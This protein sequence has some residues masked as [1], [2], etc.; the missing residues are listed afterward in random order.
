MP[1]AKYVARRGSVEDGMRMITACFTRA[2]QRCTSRI[3]MHFLL[4]FQE[5]MPISKTRNQLTVSP[6]L[7]DGV[8][9]ASRCVAPRWEAAHRPPVHS[10]QE[11]SLA[12]AG[13]STVL[14]SGLPQDYALQ[15]VQGR[16]F[17]MGQSKA[18]QWIH[19]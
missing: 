3:Y 9:S 15:V 1:S 6:A 11:L 8:P 10:L 7:R 17:G 2:P 14:H 16:L 18:N 4:T 12:N 19:V 5:I 13:R